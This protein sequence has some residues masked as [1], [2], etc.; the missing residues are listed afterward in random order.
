MEKD[1]LQQKINSIDET[2]KDLYLQRMDLITNMVKT[3]K[4]YDEYESN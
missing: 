1:E 3:N 4:E 2:L